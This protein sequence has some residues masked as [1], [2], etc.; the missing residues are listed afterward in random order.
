VINNG[1][2]EM[3]IVGIEGMTSDQLQQAVT[4]G[5]RFVVYQY[6]ISVLVMSFKRSSSVHFVPAGES[7]FKPGAKFVALSLLAGWW[8]FPWG[9][10]WTISTV[11]SNSRG[12]IDVTSEVLTA[13]A[14]RAPLQAAT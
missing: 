12:G 11:F 1:S 6:C 10:I 2:D 5:G 4:Q 9:P 14:P 13:L 7:A 3:K 8:G